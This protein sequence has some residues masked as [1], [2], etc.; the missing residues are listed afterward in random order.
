MRGRLTLCCLCLRL[1]TQLNNPSHMSVARI[2]TPLFA[3]TR[4]GK[5]SDDTFS[6][7]IPN[8]EAKCT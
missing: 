4:G 5:T 7:N 8:R 6:Y 1:N 2:R 3:H